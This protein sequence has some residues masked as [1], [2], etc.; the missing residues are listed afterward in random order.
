[1]Q[2]LI[3]AAG[4]GTRLGEYTKDKPKCMV[5]IN[6]KTLIETQ[7]ESL[8]RNGINKIIIACGYKK[9]KIIEHLAD[10]YKECE[11]IFIENNKYESTNN[12]Y[13]LYLAKEYLKQDDTI[14]L[15]SDLILQDDIIKNVIKSNGTDVIAVSKYKNWMDG[16]CVTIDNN[17]RLNKI[18]TKQY[19]DEDKT[20]QYYK[21]IN[22]YKL[23]KTFCQEK[24]IP[25]LENYIHQGKTSNY[26]EEVFK[27]LEDEAKMN[28]EIF[29][30]EKW[31]E[32][33]TAY[34]LDVAKSLFEKL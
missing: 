15:E 34:D 29:D 2:A 27:E 10:K 18:Y 24:Y 9:E 19:F 4:M 30:K 33:D 8:I 5:E 22:I 13:T 7:V 20:D 17:M 28:V 32:I 14:L 6:N 26:Y 11:F 25:N 23:S 21:T 12:I 31:Y 3:L 16:T 1:M